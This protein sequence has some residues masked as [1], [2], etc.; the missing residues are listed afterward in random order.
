[1]AF[2]E[3]GNTGA[4][5]LNPEQPVFALA[6]VCLGDEEAAAIVASFT[7]SARELKF[8]TLRRRTRSRDSLLRFISRDVSQEHFKTTLLHKR[9]MVTAKLVDLVIEPQ[10]HLAGVDLYA[11]G[12]NIA[13][14][15]VLHTCLPLFLGDAAFSNLQSHF[16]D[17]VRLRSPQ[18]AATFHAL[19]ST[20]SAHYRSAAFAHLLAIIASSSFDPTAHGPYRPSEL[21]PAIPSFVQHCAA[22]G[23][24]LGSRFHLVHD[25]SKPIEYEREFLAMLMPRDA[26]TVTVGADRRTFQL[27]LKATGIRLAPSHTVP[28]LQLADLVAS[29]LAYVGRYR[30]TGAGDH[31]LVQDLIDAGLLKAVVDGVWPSADVAPQDLGTPHI[32]GASPMMDGLSA[33]IASYM[34]IPHGPSS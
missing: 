22:W 31:A 34:R 19:T 4:D 18:A 9:F 12:G 30:A 32:R 10:L 17:M 16:L 3:A 26:P 28:Q 23:E 7:S 2:D 29:A 8:A 21:D 5:L 15:N 1:M 24:H 33:V 14:A 11:G 13:M 25:D 27:P 6:S 20:L